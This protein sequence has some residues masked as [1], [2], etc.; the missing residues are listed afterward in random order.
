M[1]NLFDEF[2]PVSYNDWLAQLQ[3][4][5]KDKSLND[6]IS[7]PEKDIEIKAYYHPQQNNFKSLNPTAANDIARNS[8]EWFI[9]KEYT[10]E[11]NTT[12]LSDLNDGINA[13][14]VHAE[15][16]QSFDQ[17]TKGILFEHIIADVKF[18]NLKSA[19]E[20]KTPEQCIL[21]FDIISLN[22][23]IGETKFSLDDFYAFYQKNAKHKSIW[24]NGFCYGKA[25]ATTVQELAFTL[26]H[27][28]EYI[29]FLVD[30]KEDLNSIV[31]KITIE[32]SVNENYF[33]NLSKFRA[34]RELIVL[35]LSAYGY[36]IEQQKSIPIYAKTS[37]RHLTQNDA[38]NNL[39]RQT[40]QAMSAILGGCNVLTVSTLQNQPEQ[41]RLAKNIQ[42][43]LKEESYFDKV[44]DPA[45]GSYFIEDLTNQLIEKSWKL[46]QE[47][48]EQGG[49]IDAVK[50]N[51]I[52]NWITENQSRYIEQVNS[53][54][55]TFLGINKFQSKLETWIEP[56]SP[57][58]KQGKEFD[59]LVPFQLENYFTQK[60]L[61]Q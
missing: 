47:I 30:K 34:I 27:L 40:T 57:E 37:G 16:Q 14:S 54:Q 36:N 2:K 18:D 46:F 44:V 1:K 53:N 6:L 41:N 55:K 20:I 17:L 23:K 61:A 42:L 13:I 58:N 25:G 39:L 52:Q 9:R 50:K 11:N 12:I 26:A 5:L 3:K 33:V 49:L 38:N 35:V 43:I 8:N 15:S 45:A 21:N 29:Q 7:F 28:N 10:S 59:R 56:K 24:V 51:K 32:L 60:N 4:D 31:N 22:Q 48:E 19:T